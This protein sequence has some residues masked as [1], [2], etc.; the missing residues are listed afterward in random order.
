MTS[1]YDI[2]S[3]R[4]LSTY[5][6]NSLHDSMNRRHIIVFLFL[7]AFVPVRSSACTSVIIP[8]WAMAD[9]RPLMWKNRDTDHLDNSIRHFKGEKY[10]FVGLVNSDSE[11]GEV[12]I[13]ANTAGFAVMNTASYCLKNDNVPVSEMDRE[14]RLMYRALEICATLEDFETFL[15]TLSRPMGVEANFGCIDASGG[16]AWYETGNTSYHKIDVNACSEGFFVVTNF[17]V[18]GDASRW[19][20][21]ERYRTAYGIF[22]EMESAG[23]LSGLHPLD[24]VD[25]L[26][27]SYRHAVLGIDLTHDA[28]EFLSHT[29]GYAVDQDFI[30]RRSTSAS[31]VIKGVR[32]GDDPAQAVLWAALGYP[33]VSVT[34]PVPVSVEPH[35]PSALS[36]FPASE[37]L[38]SFCG[39]AGYLKGGYVFM[40]GVSNSSHYVCLSHVLGD[41]EWARSTLSCCRDAERKIRTEFEDI[42]NDFISGKISEEEYLRRYD[43]ISAGFFGIYRESFEDYIHWKGPL[44]IR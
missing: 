21:V 34:V 28:E 23:T 4:Q 27:R 10:S 19:K 36:R 20:G 16:A 2:V 1:Q 41:S 44:H 18:S 13:G 26:S 37:D 35:V 12:W 38:S 43:S 9:G 32:K 5:K 3:M 24:V 39:L 25:S 11:G 22:S 33:S 42:Y 40:D 6:L 17:S 31:V 30:P 15:D 8:G 14:G 7:L 29:N